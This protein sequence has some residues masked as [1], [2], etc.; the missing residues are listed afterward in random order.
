MLET[1]ED[2]MALREQCMERQK[3]S[4]RPVPQVSIQ[5]EVR[6]YAYYNGGTYAL[7]YDWTCM[8]MEEK[9]RELEK[10]KSND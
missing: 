2:A 10:G 4:E 7:K 1:L 5:R 3:H 8:E 6:Y 9:L